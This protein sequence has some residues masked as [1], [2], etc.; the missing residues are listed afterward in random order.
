M[1]RLLFAACLVFLYGMDA[2]AQ[3]TVEIQP[4]KDTSLYEEGDISNGAG[5]FL[6]AGNNNQNNSR[7]ALLSFDIAGKIPAGSTIESVELSLLLTRTMNGFQPMEL[8]RLTADWGEGLSNAPGEEGMGA[9]AEVGDATWFSRFFDTEDWTNAGGDFAPTPSALRV[10]DFEGR[11]VWGSTEEMV[12]DAQRWLDNPAANFGWILI[13]NEIGPGTSKRFASRDSTVAET[14]P[15][16]TVTY[17][18]FTTGNA[19]DEQPQL[20]LLGQ[21]YP[22]PVNGITTISFSLAEAQHVRLDVFDMLGRSVD[23]LLDAQRNQ[24]QHEVMFDATSL[25]PGVYFYRL[26]SGSNS[27]TRQFVF[28]P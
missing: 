17:T 9:P 28:A 12:E 26:T 16:L 5:Q 25:Q 24:G 8:Y 23:T 18:P 21:N 10:V 1:I 3:T 7:R 15:F 4:T 6:F 19:D 22:N 27:V 11:Y 13:G 20:T 2:S 14:R